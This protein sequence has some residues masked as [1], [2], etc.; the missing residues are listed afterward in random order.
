MPLVHALKYFANGGEFAEIFAFQIAGNT[1]NSSKS[2]FK[3]SV[4]DMV[5]LSPN[6]I[7]C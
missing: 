7:S 6:P 4:A 2:N 3:T 5:G 1:V